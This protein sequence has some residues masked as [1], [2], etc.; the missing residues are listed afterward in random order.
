LDVVEPVDYTGIIYT[1]QN[2]IVERG[3]IGASVCVALN[4]AWAIRECV[5]ELI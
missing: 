5:R 3:N 1:H 4:D 2:I